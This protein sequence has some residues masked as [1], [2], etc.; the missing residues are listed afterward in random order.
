[1]LPNRIFAGNA[2]ACAAVHATLRHMNAI[3]MAGRA[4]AMGEIVTASLGWLQDSPISL[5][6]NGALWVIE[7]PE[8]M[9]IQ[10]AL[11]GI[12]GAGV[13]IGFSA[14]QFRILPAATIELYNLERSCAV[15]AGRRRKIIP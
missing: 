8:E 12:Y 1:M 2:L 6:G 9:D 15:A 11:V 4:A 3:D 13:C 5:R 14:R 7:L 10:S